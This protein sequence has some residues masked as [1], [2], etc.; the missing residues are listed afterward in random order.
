M[1]SSQI[2]LPDIPE[3]ISVPTLSNC[4]RLLVLPQ[5]FQYTPFNESYR[6]RGSERSL[7]NLKGFVDLPINIVFE[8]A[9]YL[10]P[11]DLLQLSQLSK[12]FKS[13]FASRS[14]LFV[15]CT[16]FHNLNIECLADINEL[17][18]ASLLYDECCMVQPL[19]FS[20]HMTYRAHDLLLILSGM[21]TY[22]DL[23]SIP[24]AVSE[25]MSRLPNCKPRP[26]P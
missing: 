13:I 24:H 19:S 3:D 4:F 5:R 26:Y 15:W 22:H 18:F 8:T 16:A 6:T 17:Q 1:S 23:P 14:A 2:L 10:G 11:K 12:Q 9:M 7:G 21:W 20:Y 25:V